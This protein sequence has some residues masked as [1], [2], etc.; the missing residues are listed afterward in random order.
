MIP[1]R[2]RNTRVIKVGMPIFLV[3]LLGW[4]FHGANM[5]PENNVYVT[6]QD[7][8]SDCPPGFKKNKNNECISQNL[9]KQYSLKNQLGVGGLK[10][11]LPKLREGFSPEQIDLGRYLFFD[12]AL[13]GDGS[14]SCATCHDPQ[15]GFADGR[16]TSVGIH[17]RKGKRS[18]PS[19][20]NVGYLKLLF[21]DGR[22]KSLEEQMQGPLYSEEEMGNTPENL[23]KTLN[24]NLNYKNLFAQAFPD[25]VDRDSI[26]LN[27]IYTALAAF[28]ASLVSLNSKYDQYAHGYHQALNQKEIEGLNVFRSFVARCAECHTPPLFTNQ[29]IAVIGS[30]EPDGLPLDPGAET[31]SRDKTLRGGFKVPSLRNIAKS[32]PY[33]HSGRF[34][35]LRETVAFYTGG[36]GHAVPKDEDLILHWHIWEPQLTDY[37]LDRLV[38]FL[39]TLTDESFMPKPPDVL[40]GIT[41][42][43]PI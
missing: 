20:W 43:S 14:I 40:P 32:A 1:D 11:A 37:E 17:N 25:K 13:S 4:L 12:P 10:T 39:N 29:Q 27:E 21:W 23:L 35:T 31:P 36:R 19:L 30:P 42:K 22:A 16:A 3:V 24:D 41:N 33:M 34:E 28:E 6:V 5:R 8:S 2:K 9:Y 15:K 26:Q 18:A 38:D 7:L